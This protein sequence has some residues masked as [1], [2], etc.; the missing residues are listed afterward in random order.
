MLVYLLVCSFLLSICFISQDA[1]KYT[2][3]VLIES[4]RPSLDALR[5]GFLDTVPAYI[6]GKVTAEELRLLLNGSPCISVA[7]LKKRTRVTFDTS[8][9]E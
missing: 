2:K 4:A 6:L 9:N 1:E 8:R 5:E 7:E 3:L